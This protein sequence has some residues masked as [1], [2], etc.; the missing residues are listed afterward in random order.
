MMETSGHGALRENRYLDDG[1]FL[2]VK[3]VIELVR[4]FVDLG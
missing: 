1:A 2:A 4:V 3:A